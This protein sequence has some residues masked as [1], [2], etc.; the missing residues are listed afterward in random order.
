MSLSYK[1]LVVR[2][3]N[4]FKPVKQMFLRRVLAY[5][6]EPTE[7]QNLE[8]ERKKERRERNKTRRK[9]GGETEKQREKGG[10]TRNFL[11]TY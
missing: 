6:L 4:P 3:R 10:K 7:D 2:Y 9:E 8:V 11:V 1:T 5:L